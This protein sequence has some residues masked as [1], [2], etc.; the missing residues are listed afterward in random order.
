[1]PINI[2]VDD[3]RKRI[4]YLCESIW[5]LPT[6]IDELGKWVV[7]LGGS[8]EKGTYAADIGFTIRA[9][10]SG[11]GAELTPK[12]MSALSK[13]NISVLFSEYPGTAKF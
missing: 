6:Q 12:I 1:M 2:F 3:S 5:D 9:D 13:F 8:L 4:A 10:A 7:E 11:G